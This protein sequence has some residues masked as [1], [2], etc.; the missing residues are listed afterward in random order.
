[1]DQLS[2]VI[3]INPIVLPKGRGYVIHVTQQSRP[4]TAPTQS[5]M[6]ALQFI[7][8]ITHNLFFFFFLVFLFK[9]KLG[10]EKKNLPH[11]LWHRGKTPFRRRQTLGKSPPS[12]VKT[13]STYAWR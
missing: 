12:L 5:L 1:M 6:V 13:A 3:D 8:I 9:R 2:A 11:Q 7:H 10:K 4:G